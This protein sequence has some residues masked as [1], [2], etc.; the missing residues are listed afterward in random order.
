M[1]SP[2]MNFDNPSSRDTIIENW[3][4][5][6]CPI[7]PGRE[8]ILLFQK[9]LKSIKEPRVLI[10]GCTPE[11]VDM[12][13]EENPL[14]VTI[15]DWFPP[16]IAAMKKMAAKNWSR[17]EVI[18]RDWRTPLDDLKDRYN[19][20]L[21]DGPFTFLGFPEDYLLICRNLNRYVSDGGLVVI[22]NMV[23]MEGS[24]DELDTYYRQT[25]NRLEERKLEK[26]DPVSGTFVK[27]TISE[28]WFYA[29]FKAN[30]DPDK[31][32]DGQWRYWT[33]R[34]SCDL[35]EIFGEPI[36]KVTEAVLGNRGLNQSYRE[37]RIPVR[38]IPRIEEMIAL[39]ESC[40]YLLMENISVG[41]HPVPGIWRIVT[42]RNMGRFH[43]REH[44][45][46]SIP[47]ANAPDRSET[48]EI[49]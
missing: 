48:G 12:V 22:R 44:K 46:K 33:G 28:L 27:N 8:E 17:V 16:N 45:G 2:S 1:P 40:N 20:V 15:M 6:G 32:C 26:S 4:M 41:R 19:I 11:L 10:L 5:F 47:R 37:Q 18:I 34:V 25:M 14:R 38:S 31:L 3:S 43:Q 42:F 35:F 29:F 21:G 23:W 13:L 30:T 49:T 36:Y 9:K 7:R 24:P 39:F